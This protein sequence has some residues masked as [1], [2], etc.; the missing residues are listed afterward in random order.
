MKQ[1]QQ[2]IL[3]QTGIVLQNEVVIWSRDPEVQR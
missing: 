2:R 3:E 1:I